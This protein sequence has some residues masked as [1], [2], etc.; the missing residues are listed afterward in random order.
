[1][2]M[3]VPMV[4]ASC[5]KYM[6]MQLFN[7]NMRLKNSWNAN[8]DSEVI[9]CYELHKLNHSANLVTC[10]TKLKSSKHQEVHLLNN[11]FTRHLNDRA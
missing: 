9:P 7:Y 2:R 1:M 10:Q 6:Y 11:L 3:Q 8:N 4:T 5:L